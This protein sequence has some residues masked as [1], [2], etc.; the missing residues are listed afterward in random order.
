MSSRKDTGHLDRKNN[1]YM[2]VSVPKRTVR[3]YKWKD[4]RVLLLDM[5][6][7][8][9]PYTG[10]KN[11]DHL[12][13]FKSPEHLEALCNEY[14]ASCDGVMYHKNG[15]PMRDKNGELLIGQIKPYTI[16]GLARYLDI[17]TSK[18]RSYEQGLR[19]SI[20]FEEIEEGE[21][22]GQRLEYSTVLRRARQ[23]IEEFA[24][25][26]LYDRD[27]FNGAKFVLDH[28]YKWIGQKEQAEIYNMYKQCNLKQAEFDLKKSTIDNNGGIEPVSIKIVRASEG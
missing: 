22:T 15:I 20:G 2:L 5:R 11:R 9:K 8:H 18:L 17:D 6:G 24:E 16:S 7:V 25:T 21:E 4:N 10:S 28:A 14:F 12:R 1:E 23:R 27:G 13:K 26:R 19:D 3:R